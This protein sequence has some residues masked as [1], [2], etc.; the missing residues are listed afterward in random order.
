MFAH[1]ARRRKFERKA[2]QITRGDYANSLLNEK[3]SPLE[4]VLKDKNDQ[5]TM[6][7]L[8]PTQKR[9]AL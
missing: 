8:L 3:E 9:K 5:C 7:I 1:A 2:M 6:K 4:I